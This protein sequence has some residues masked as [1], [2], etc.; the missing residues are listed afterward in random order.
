MMHSSEDVG[1]SGSL[2]LSPLSV[3]TLFSSSSF[4]DDSPK[5]V[6]AVIV[7]G[8]NDGTAARK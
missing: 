8:R 1:K 3:E 2:L 7:G 6:E 5:T 4:V